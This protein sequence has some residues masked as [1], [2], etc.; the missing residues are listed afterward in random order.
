[1]TIPAT[2]TSAHP[3]RLLRSTAAVLLGFIAVVVL[4]LATDQLL[5]VLDVY[6]PWGQPM[7]DTGDNLL[8]LAYRILYT[9]I[10][11]YIA[12]RLAP[13]NPMRHALVL[14]V[15][16]SVVG[17]AAA[18]ATIPMGLGPA[19]YPIALAVTG[20]PSCWVGG[21]LHRVTQRER[22]WSNAA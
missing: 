14:G 15:I 13:H 6:P 11:G 4:S 10:G 18:V 9:V 1:M 22:S 16:G 5:H 3:R 21:V 20:L 8:A 19:W 12:A 7:Y 2:K 17:A